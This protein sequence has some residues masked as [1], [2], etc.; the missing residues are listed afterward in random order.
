MFLQELPG[1]DLTREQT[2][3]ELKRFKSAMDECAVGVVRNSK[4]LTDAQHVA[5][6]RRLGPLLPMKMLLK[7]GGSKS[8]FAFAEIIDIGNIDADGRILPDDDRRRA[9]NRGN[10]L[11][12]T[13]VSYDP[14][15]G[16]YSLL[17]AHIVPP[18]GAPTEF[19]DMRAAWDSL[20]EGKK[21]QVENLLVE[22]SV[23][24]SRERA[25]MA[26]TEDERATR[27]PSRHK[28]AHRHPGSGRMTLYLAAHASHVVGWPL[29]EGRA[30]LKELMD[31]ATQPQFVRRHRHLGQPLHHAPRHAVRRYAPS[32][33][34][35]QDDGAGKGR[36]ATSWAPGGC[37]PPSGLPRASRPPGCRG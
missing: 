21:R 34:H 13:D 10:L 23:W 26:V 8:R 19:A 32:A 28:L 16:T 37:C 12:H 6:S 33:R 4:P 36:L 35:A 22:H 9:Y 24:Y 17:S 7:V 25:G 15:R 18:G 20:P 29:E 31:F 3:E 1:F 2:P 14:A 30:L 27:P 5:F 11:W